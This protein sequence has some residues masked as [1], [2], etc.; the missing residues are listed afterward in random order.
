MFIGERE[1]GP[2]PVFLKFQESWS[3]DGHAA[4]GMV[5]VYSLTFIN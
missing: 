1:G 2:L 4:R 5:M 3:K